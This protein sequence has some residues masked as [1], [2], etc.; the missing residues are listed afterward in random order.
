MER[1]CLLARCTW[2]RYVPDYGKDGFIITYNELGEPEDGK[3]DVQVKATDNIERYRVKDTYYFDLDKRDLESWLTAAGSKEP[4]IL[5]LY[6][7]RNSIAYMLEI[8]AYFSDKMG[9]FKKINK[10]VRV[11]IPAERVL[12]PELVGSIRLDKNRNL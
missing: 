2:Q 1:Q 5:V 4:L 12:T 6:D 8:G 10:F 11:Y 3:I 7:A 9:G